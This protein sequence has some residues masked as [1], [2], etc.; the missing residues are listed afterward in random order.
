MVQKLKIW[1]T[2]ACI[3]LT[4]MMSGCFG[5]MEVNDRAFVQL[6]GLE[7]QDDIYMVT[8][9][10]YKSES[11]STDP[12]V[13]KANSFAVSGEGATISDAI[14]NAE[15][16]LGKRAFLGH[17]KLLIIG[18][19]IENPADELALFLDGSVSPSCPVVYSDDPAAAAGTLLEDGSFSAEQIVRLMD[20]AASQGKTVYTS[21][22]DVASQAGVL[23]C[24]AALPIMHGSGDTV[25]FEGL[26]FA[27]KNGTSGLIADADVLGVKLLCGGFESGDSVTVP[28]TVGEKRAAMKIIGAKSCI[29][30]EFSEGTLH[31]YTD[32]KLKASEA[33]NPDGI[34]AELLEK[35]L[36]QSIND[37]CI[38]A[39]STAVWYSGCDIFGIKKLVRRDCPEMYDAYCAD[40][41]RYLAESVLTLRV[42][43]QGHIL[44][45]S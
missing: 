42:S 30:T 20:S 7:R 8:L 15:I 31:I 19:G 35:A 37:T 23:N 6:M 18:S 26:T 21:I 4:L 40:E 41:G 28:I 17:I 25:K 44:T 3:I 32:V 9:Q 22:A 2:T 38:S 5:G 11:G 12:D 43:T 27:R 34:S 10:I 33:E 45:Q 24:A 16:S 1:R 36:R 29:K 14:A 13:S 39:F